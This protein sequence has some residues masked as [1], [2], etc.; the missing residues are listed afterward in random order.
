MPVTAV[1][2]QS[3]R[4]V[5]R[6]GA[7]LSPSALA[8]LD[9]TRRCLARWGVAKTTLDDVAR[10]A[11]VSRASVYRMFPGG[12]DALLAALVEREAGV[13]ID[14]IDEHVQ[15][16]PDLAEALVGAISI[17]ARTIAGHL[18][19]QYLLE[20]E[21]GLVLPHLAFARL[22]DLFSRVRAEGGS[23]LARFVD[24][25]AARSERIAEW[26]ARLTLSYTFSPS[27]GVDLTNEE[28]AR[29]LVHTFVMPGIANL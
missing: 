19:L 23:M 5:A 1:T 25:D 21:A 7:D 18:A 3:P 20:H 24:G 16:A 28:S 26:V 4:S 15:S 6:A 29:S 2:D 14:Q 17:T 10:E 27:T 11:G 13:Y 9:G 8:V 22:D 12:K